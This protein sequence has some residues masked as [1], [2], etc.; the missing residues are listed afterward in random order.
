MRRREKLLSM[1]M[2]GACL[3]FTGD[4]AEPDQVI[5]MPKT[6]FDF[7][8]QKAYESHK[9]QEV[10]T[11]NIAEIYMVSGGNV[12]VTTARDE[13]HNLHE[14]EFINTT[15]YQEYPDTKSTIIGRE[16]MVKVPDALL[17]SFHMV[18]ST[19]YNGKP[20]KVYAE[21]KNDMELNMR[22]TKFPEYFKTNDFTL[23]N[24][25]FLKVTDNNGHTLYIDTNQADWGVVSDTRFKVI[26]ENR[27]VV[28]ASR[29]TSLDVQCRSGL[30][31][32]ELR[33]ITQGTGL[34]GIEEAVLQIEQQYG[35]NPLFTLALAA[36]ESAWG[37]SAFATTR[38]NL[39]GIAAYDSNVNAAY[40]FRSK[41][42]CVRFFGE[43]IHEVYFM[44][45]RTTIESIHAKYAS[46][47]GWATK[48]QD[49]MAQMKNQ[50]D[51]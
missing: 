18:I 2:I 9:Q 11:T 44:E 38:N 30:T 42:D 45:G 15:Q 32:D 25:H 4:V 35:I 34:E 31:A 21:P 10:V 12:T 26:G 20:V 33:V 39:F 27:R 5:A 51:A 23:Y 40:S 1:L 50:L 29:T 46:D 13:I 19:V 24:K 48:L 7:N 36:H 16:H 14:G 3:H 22:G 41:S 47:P 43:M 6:I 49:T 17:N 28:R 8:K 37:S